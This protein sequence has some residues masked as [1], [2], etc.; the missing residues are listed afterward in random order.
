MEIRQKNKF[1]VPYH[2]YT[3]TL[4]NGNTVN[5]EVAWEEHWG[6]V[7]E[8]IPTDYPDEETYN[9][10]CDIDVGWGNDDDG[11]QIIDKVVD[12]ETGQELNVRDWANNCVWCYIDNYSA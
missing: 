2:S 4:R 9:E 12:D 11:H 1:G 6:N 10:C 3:L 5:C 8:T 7:Q